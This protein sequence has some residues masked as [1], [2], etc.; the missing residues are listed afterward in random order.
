[1]NSEDGC[2]CISFATQRQLLATAL[3][4]TILNIAHECEIG[5]A[6]GPEFKNHSSIGIGV[7]ALWAGVAPGEQQNYSA[8]E[9]AYRFVDMH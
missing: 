3:E 6:A 9:D 8:C 7:D 4:G 1:M 5:F 2:A